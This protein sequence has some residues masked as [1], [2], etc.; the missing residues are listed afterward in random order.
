MGVRSVML[1][2]SRSVADMIKTYGIKEGH[3]KTYEIENAIYNML[4]V[5]INIVV[6]NVSWGIR[7]RYKSLHECDIL[8]L[9]KSN[10]ATE[11]E[12]KVSIADLKKDSSKPH[13]HDH[14]LIKYLYFVVPE[15]MKSIALELIP[16]RAGLML[17]SRGDE[18]GSLEIR[19]ER[20]AKKRKDV[21]K[22]TLKQREHLAHLGAMRIPRYLSKIIS[23][24]NIILDLKDNL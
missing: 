12:I 11:Y 3:I 4:D 9:T 8:S 10:Y 17:V 6:P 18:E 7:H 13:G 22:W 24:K 23:L 21:V 14:P 2:D 15:S 19:T 16:E 20:V 5:R 1:V